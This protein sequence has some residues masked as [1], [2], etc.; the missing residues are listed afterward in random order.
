MATFT[1]RSESVGQLSRFLKHPMPATKRFTSRTK[2][3]SRVL[4]SSESIKLMEEKD[5]EKEQRRL[6]TGMKNRRQGTIK[7]AHKGTVPGV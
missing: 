7:D 5:L 4:T 2:A 6:K 1:R 3:A